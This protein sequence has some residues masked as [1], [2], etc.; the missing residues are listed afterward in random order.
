VAR[1]R[2]RVEG[3]AEHFVLAPDGRTA[4]VVSLHPGTVTPI[5]TA[6]AKAGQPISLQ[7]AP[8]YIAITP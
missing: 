2:I 4:Y 1:S 7:G 6:T 3:S 5:I 8:A